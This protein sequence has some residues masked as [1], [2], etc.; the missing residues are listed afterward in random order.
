MDLFGAATMGVDPQTGS[1]LTKEQRVAMF[2]ASRGMGGGSRRGDGAARPGVNPQSAIVVS[3]PKLGE[4]VQ[5][6]Q[7]SYEKTAENINDQVQQNKNNIQLLFD[8]VLE[9]RKGEIAEEKKETEQLK[10]DRAT[11]LRRARESLL[12]NLAKATSGFMRAGEAA[13]RK[14]VKPVEGFMDRLRKALLL[15]VGAWAIDNLPTIMSKLEDFTKNLPTLQEFIEKDL[16][17]I[18]GAWSILDNGLKGVKKLVGKIGTAAFDVA[19]FITKK[20]TKFIGKI[21]NNISKFLGELLEKAV[22]A[23]AGWASKA[24]Q[25]VADIVTPKPRPPAGGGPDVPKTGGGR[26]AQGQRLA[27]NRAATKALPGSGPTTQ[28]INKLF[29]KLTDFGKSVVDN[30]RTTLGNIGGSISNKLSKFAGVPVK[31]AAERTGWIKSALGPVIDKFPQ[32]AKGLGKV[33]GL[34]K[35]ALRV[36]P[37]LGFAIDLALNK[38]VAGQDW[39]QAIMRSLG[40][41]IVG[42][43]SAAVGA[44]LG[45]AA[46]AGVGVLAG[47]VGAIPGAAIGAALGAVI[48]GIAGGYAGDQVGAMGYETFTGNERSENRVAGGAVVNAISDTLTG[49]TSA[50]FTPPDPASAGSGTPDFT[51]KLMEMGSTP[52]GMQ[53]QSAF[54]SD[55]QFID[56]PGEVTDLRQPQETPVEKAESQESADSLPTYSTRDPDMD[57]YRIYATDMFQLVN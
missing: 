27:A 44:K 33:S 47:G 28:P 1:Y 17:S 55:V 18:R 21:F 3:K 53:I 36:V 52:A 30:A 16:L 29:G 34:L 12:D 10:K 56:L 9:T 11:K 32:L 14:I 57:F 51:K 38:G 25:G 54:S 49:D 2:R 24:V 13:G 42:G 26:S 50:I 40:S 43:V 22:K 41:S 19:K 20:A 46:G 37:G 7:K 4:I 39:T 5:T 8:S 35:G 48:A 45:A 15:L 23:L 6:L 31:P